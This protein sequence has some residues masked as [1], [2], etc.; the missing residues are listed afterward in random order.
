[1]SHRTTA[2][3]AAVVA[4]GLAV[5]ACSST[6][7]S[8][9]DRSPAVIHI[10]VQTD[11]PGL[12]YFDGQVRSGFEYDLANWLADRLGKKP[13]FV[14]L[15]PDARE[16][17]L[18]DGGVELMIGTYSQTDAREREGVA[19]VGPY[20]IT[21]QGM[22]V[23]AT[24]TAT[25][26]EAVR[27]SGTVCAAR[28]TTSIAQLTEL[29]YRPFEG[30]G[31]GDCVRSLLLGESVRAVSTDQ[32]ILRGWANADK[33]LR[34]VDG[35]FGKQE[36]YGIGLRQGNRD[37]CE[38]VTAALKEYMLSGYWETHFRNRFGITPA[39]GTKPDVNALNRC[40]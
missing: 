16:I 8:E 24:D 2:G 14:D 5:T 6:P 40:S 17:A 34:V 25:D 20:L 38:R 31:D 4:L 13:Y 22:L 28:G 27:S 26:A 36:R 19:F 39:P 35:V 9:A 21:Q 7:S 15:K 3:I 18:K 10:G 37:L 23:L 11:Q 32:L 29:G 12:G 30:I 1:M 33:R